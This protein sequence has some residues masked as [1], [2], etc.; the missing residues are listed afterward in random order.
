V[1]ACGRFRAIWVKTARSRQLTRWADFPKPV[2]RPFGILRQT[3]E[4]AVCWPSHT[5]VWQ[6][7]AA[8]GKPRSSERHASCWITC[9]CTGR[10]TSRSTESRPVEANCAGNRG[11]SVGF[12]SPDCLRRVGSCLLATADVPRLA[13]RAAAP[14]RLRCHAADARAYVGR[15]AGSTARLLTHTASPTS[16][17]TNGSPRRS[18]R[19]SGART[20]GDMLS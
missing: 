18:S 4:H 11:V 2:I 14:S 1:R 17:T 19:S 7:S 13:A 8:D 5:S 9:R 3:L 10:T 12:P 15:L 16:W 20:P 6:A